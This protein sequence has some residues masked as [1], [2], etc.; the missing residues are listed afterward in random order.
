M[1]V[2]AESYFD[3]TNTHGGGERLCVAGYIF[4]KDAAEQ[5][6]IRWAELID[7]WKIPYFHMVECAHN[8]EKFAHLTKDECDLAAREAIQIIKE[9][10]SMGVAV[11][12]LESDYLEIMPQVAFF[13]SAYDSCARDVMTGVSSWIDG[14]N[15]N[16]LMHYFFEDGTDTEANAS[17]CILQMMKDPEIR[18]E[19]CY[20][21]HSFVPKILSPG[22]QAADI[23]AWHAGQDCKRALRGDPIRK[24][25]ASLCEIPHRCVHISREILQERAFMIASELQE[26]GLTPELANLIHKTGRSTRKP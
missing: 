8:V 5:Q 21:G 13:G 18:K 10:A 3:E 4:S 24:D 19:A 26:A 6:A 9:T 22:V 2:L 25:F 14:S 7:K 23:F 15:F 16:G 1:L 20:G 17:Y 11:T 12:V